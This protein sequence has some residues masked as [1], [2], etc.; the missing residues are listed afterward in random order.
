MVLVPAYFYSLSSNPEIRIPKLCIPCGMGGLQGG[1][2]QR[3]Y[4]ES[5]KSRL[6]VKTGQYR[7]GK[8]LGYPRHETCLSPVALCFAEFNSLQSLS[9][10]GNS[11]LYEAIECRASRPRLWL[12][13]L[14]A[15]SR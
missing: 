7:N 15:G 9:V 2:A 14:H 6:L 13:C 11:L 4:L 12:D 5:A 1:Q 3:W 8:D 10:Y